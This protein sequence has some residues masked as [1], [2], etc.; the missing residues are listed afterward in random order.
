MYMYIYIYVYIYIYICI[1]TYTYARICLVHLP[2]PPPRQGAR[3][4]AAAPL[5]PDGGAV[6]VV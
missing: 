1:Y 6:S 5:L 4:P 2:H 3:L